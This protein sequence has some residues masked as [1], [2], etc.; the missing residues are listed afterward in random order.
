VRAR[1]TRFSDLQRLLIQVLQTLNGPPVPSSRANTAPYI[2]GHMSGNNKWD[3]EQ[4]KVAHLSTLLNHRHNQ[5]LQNGG[6][7]LC[8]SGHL[9]EYDLTNLRSEGVHTC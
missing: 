4:L 6:G 1:T 9:S 8:A 5:G 2:V 3:S 7:D